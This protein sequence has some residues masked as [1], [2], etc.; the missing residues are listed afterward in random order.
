MQMV[1]M[2]TWVANGGYTVKPTLLK[3]DSDEIK[4]E[5][6]GFSRHYLLEVLEG[7]KAVVNKKGGT[8]Y[9][10][11]FDVAGQ[12][13]GGKTASTQIRRI[14]LAEREEGLK[15]QH[16]LAWKDRDHAFFAGYAPVDK[17]RYAIAVA[18]E[19]GGGGGM[20]AA[21]IASSIMRQALELEIEDKE[22]ERQRIQESVSKLNLKNK[23]K[24]FHPVFVDEEEEAEN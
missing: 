1:Q 22:N 10:T 7:L 5:S 6:L 8:A 21:P 20:V 13:M 3:Q 17:P 2:M 16:E 12:R 9:H 15:Q 18:V 19:H 24:I 4:S 11:R 14:S 23:P